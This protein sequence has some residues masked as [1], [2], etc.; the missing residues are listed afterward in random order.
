MSQ[1]SAIVR[2]NESEV[3]RKLTTTSKRSSKKLTDN[4]ANVVNEIDIDS[5]DV[6]YIAEGFNYQVFSNTTASVPPLSNLHNSSFSLKKPKALV[7]QLA[8]RL[9]RYKILSSGKCQLR[10]WSW[11]NSCLASTGFVLLLIM[12]IILGIQW[13]TARYEQWLRRHQC[14][15]HL[16]LT[17]AGQFH[18]KL[19]KTVS[20][21]DNFYQYA[22]GQHFRPHHQ[23]VK[24][25]TP[26]AQGM[27]AYQTS[28]N[29]GAALHLNQVKWR[30]LV[31]IHRPAIDHLTELNVHATIQGLHNIYNTLWTKPSSA[32]FKVAQFFS[33]CTNRMYS[34]SS[35]MRSFVQQVINS[36]GGIWL[37]DKKATNETG[38]GDANATQGWPAYMFW[39]PDIDRG[40]QLSANWS[41]MKAII[42]LQADLH[43]GVFVDFGL[44]KQ[45]YSNPKINM[46][47]YVTQ[48][49]SQF[50]T[51]AMIPYGDTE[52]TERIKLA[53]KDV[54]LVSTL[55]NKAVH[56]SYKKLKSVSLRDLNDRGTAFNWNTYF[57][58]YF[59]E[60][61]V[62]FNGD[63][64]V[65]SRYVDY[66]KSI[67]PIVEE[68]QKNYTKPVFHR[69]LNNYML[70]T[71]LS[72]YEW[73]LSDNLKPGLFNQWYNILDSQLEQTCFFLTHEL[74]GTVLSAIFVENHLNEETVNHTQ[75]MLTILKASA[76]DQIELTKWM[77]DE[78]K[79]KVE[80]R[81]DKLQIKNEVPEIMTNDA[82]L[83]YAYRNF[84]P[85][86]VY[87]ANIL[88]AVKYLRSVNN[89]ILGGVADPVETDWVSQ[90]VNMYD[91][92]IGIHIKRDELYIPLGA[93]Q[94]PV[95]HHT[96]PS[97][98]N[99]AGFGS[100]IGTAIA[101][102]LGELGS[103]KQD[104]KSTAVWTD[105]S[106]TEYLHH[107]E[108]VADHIGN[109]THLH[110]NASSWLKE[111]LKRSIE[112]NAIQVINDA[113]G[114]MIARRAL[115][116]WISEKENGVE[117]TVLP[118]EHLDRDK[119]FY[120][121]YAQT[122]CVKMH[123]MEEFYQLFH[124]D[125]TIPRE[126][127][128]NHILSETPSFAVAFQCPTGS[129]M[130]PLK[131]C[132][133]PI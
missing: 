60:I 110:F 62:T 13:H 132:S 19:N 122:F 50:A 86:A 63:Y 127:I 21:C 118:G 130:N 35:G 78:T 25:D 126:I 12:L 100:M 67:S 129:K 96:L 58:T 97:T 41:W 106:W 125:Q 52:I 6:S 30:Q 14:L 24:P 101:Q 70:W 20:P 5:A 66:L 128:V 18:A 121:T 32:K 109:D 53:V 29:R 83:N 79:R 99:F 75:S 28:Y 17:S 113:T 8:K 46:T 42:Q 77:D 16:C 92:K 107:I 69:I 54:Q 33:S 93:I 44:L 59:N 102:L 117:N 48:P 65:Y 56:G 124:E 39:S 119:F 64:V 36:I 89:R 105:R 45:Y 10:K 2:H 3:G 103:T 51:K 57:S 55:L 85:S 120:I 76:L 91:A 22:C 40:L 61:G 94:P 112:D 133:A 116:Q 80:D 84:K 81:I 82:K 87:I 72:A 26:S 90:D 11:R 71:V 111:H 49:F 4:A 43:V 88:E 74:F 123:E 1:S 98:M 68:L 47:N 104:A 27:H 37:L 34:G 23:T 108:C 31:R 7:H 73:H 15:N 95:Y 115:N 9:D 131:Q 38:A 114:L